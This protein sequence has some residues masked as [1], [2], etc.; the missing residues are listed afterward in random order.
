METNLTN[1]LKPNREEKH[2]RKGLRWRLEENKG[3][4]GR[5]KMTPFVHVAKWVL[6]GFAGSATKCE[7]QIQTF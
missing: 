2:Q 5:R 3:W 6:K 1:L 4:E 7:A